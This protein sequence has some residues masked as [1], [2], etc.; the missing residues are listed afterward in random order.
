MTPIVI[1]TTVSTTVYTT[2]QAFCSFTFPLPSTY[3][4][5]TPLTINIQAPSSA[6]NN[7][8]ITISNLN[9]VYF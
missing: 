7:I 2:K 4:A 6:L 8:A 5:G 9:I 1:S 3:T